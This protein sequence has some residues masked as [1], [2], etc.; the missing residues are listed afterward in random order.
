[1]NQDTLNEMLCRTPDG[2]VWVIHHRR[3]AVRV[4]PASYPVGDDILHAARY[5]QN[6][7]FVCGQRVGS[8]SY[9]TPELD[10]QGHVKNP[11]PC[12]GCIQRLRVLL[13]PTRQSVRPEYPLAAFN[14]VETWNHLTD[15]WKVPIEEPFSENYVGMPESKAGSSSRLRSGCELH[16]WRWLS[17][18]TPA[19]YGHRSCGK[20]GRFDVICADHEVE[21][22]RD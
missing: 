9:S 1:M 4:G 19:G 6:Q 22:E 12:A 7:K 15:E 3:K 2:V 21:N 11:T 5:D 16:E 14:L 20:C 17:G 10:D 8:S 18:P 13:E